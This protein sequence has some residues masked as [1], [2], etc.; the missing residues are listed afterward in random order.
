MFD[1]FGELF[2]FDSDG[3][4]D[5]TERAAELGFIDEI[6]DDD[7]YMGEDDETDQR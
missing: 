2:D 4:L 5:I 6:I 3:S 1:M 7:E